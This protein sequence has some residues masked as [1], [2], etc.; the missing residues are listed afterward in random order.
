MKLPRFLYNAQQVK[1]L[2]QSELMSKATESV[3]A[4]KIKPMMTRKVFKS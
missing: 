1:L 4:H 2:A 3:T